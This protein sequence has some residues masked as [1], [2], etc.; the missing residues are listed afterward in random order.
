MAL[1]QPLF[2]VEFEGLLPTRG[3]EIH[4]FKELSSGMLLRRTPFDIRRSTV[5]LFCAE[6]IYRLVREGESNRVL[7]D[8]VWHS[9]E[10]LDTIDNGV[11]VANFHLWF[12]ANL[13]RH[14][15]FMPYGDCENGMWFDI[16]SG[17]YT[18]LRPVH[19][20]SLEP[21]DALLLSRLL[22]CDVMSLADIQLS[23]ERRSVF[24]ESLLRYYSFHFDM[25]HSVRSIRILQEVL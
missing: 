1:F 22:S 20:L 11:A 12:L 3:G 7:F 9:I 13:S 4:R 24:L 15:G 18:S 10:A 25:V 5:A 23:R 21:Y 17:E 14:L 6:V 2:T 8:F 19:G 16:S